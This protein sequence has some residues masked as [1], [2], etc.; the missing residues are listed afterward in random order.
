MAT[1]TSARCQHLPT[2]PTPGGKCQ[3][4]TGPSVPRAPALHHHCAHFYQQVKRKAGIKMHEIGN[5]TNKQTY[6]KLFNFLRN[7][8]FSR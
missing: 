3:V 8:K 2:F 6:R 1:K 5:V 7:P 4:W